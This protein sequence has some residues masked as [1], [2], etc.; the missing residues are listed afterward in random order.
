MS[1]L[2][3]WLLNLLLLVI[4][5]LASHL[6]L[7]HMLLARVHHSGW[8]LDW[9]HL[10]LLHAYLVVFVSM[11][12]AYFILIMRTPPFTVNYEF[13]LMEAGWKFLDHGKRSISHFLHRDALLPLIEGAYNLDFVTTMPPGKHILREPWLHLRWRLVGLLLLKVVPLRH[14]IVVEHWLG[15]GAHLW[16]CSSLWR[17]IIT[18]CYIAW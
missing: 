14:V 6:C 12:I 16:R 1:H 2:L 11:L 8:I 15:L 13:V 9:H 4:V 3:L 18:G 5:R 10:L 17:R 7:R